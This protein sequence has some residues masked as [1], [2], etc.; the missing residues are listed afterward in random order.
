MR[1]TLA[2]LLAALVVLTGAC[3]RGTKPNPKKEPI[4]PRDAVVK[5]CIDPVASQRFEDEACEDPSEGFVWRYL[6]FDGRRELPAVGEL[7]PGRG[8]GTAPSGK[9][10]VT[11]P[12]RG[13]TFT[14]APQASP[15]R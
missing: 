10:I 13:A 6:T 4:V 2:L 7:L 5:V 14:P 8:T 15:S 9:K 12:A 1:R 11:I 3:D